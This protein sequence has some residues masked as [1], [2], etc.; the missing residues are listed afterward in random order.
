MDKEV[1]YIGDPMCSWCYGFTN[2][3]QGLR[4]KFKERARFTLV[5]GGL[6]PDGTHVAD[7]NYTTFLRG[8]WQEVSERTGQPFPF[9]ILDST[10]WIYDTEKACRAVVAMRLLKPEVEWEYFAA[11]QKGFYHHNHNPNDPAS[12]ARIA[13]GF[14]VAHDD[15]LDAYRGDASIAG[16]QDDFGRAREIGV[17]SFPTVLVRDARGL[18]ALTMGYRPLD[19]LEGPLAGWLEG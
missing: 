11:A 5:M 16:T 2:A 19:V 1:I 7:I 15:F 6:R 9:G 4:A 13:E 12:F 8:H 3:I 17:S 18:A 10:G 14:G